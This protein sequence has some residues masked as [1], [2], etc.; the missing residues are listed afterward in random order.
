MSLAAGWTCPQCDRR[1]P[2][3][4]QTCRCGFEYVP[5]SDDEIPAAAVKSEAGGRLASLLLL[6]VVLIGGGMAAGVYLTRADRLGS[7]SDRP[8][9]LDPIAG[10]PPAPAA[11]SP[12]RP[13]ESEPAE[14]RL[15]LPSSELPVIPPAATPDRTTRSIEDIVS[16]SESAVALIESGSGRGAGFF[17]SDDRVLTNA[18]VVSGQAFVTVRLSDGKTLPARIEAQL[19]DVDIALLRTSSPHPFRAALEMGSAAGVRAGQEVIAIG[20]PLGLQNTVTRGI[21]SAVRNTGGVVLIQIDASLNPGNSGGPLLDRAGRVIGINTLR[22]GGAQALGFAVAINH[23]QALLSGRGDTAVT[24]PSGG[25]GGPTLAGPA[26]S[27]SQRRQGQA[28]FERALQ[29]LSQRADQIDANWR[30]FQ[31]N[32]LVNPQSHDGQRE[33]FL[34]RDQ[35]PTFKTVDVWCANYL[36]NLKQQ[37]A[38]FSEVMARS[39][40]EA[41][42]AG[43]YPGVLREA[44]RRHR[45]DWAGWDR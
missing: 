34:V 13:N 14:P 19:P 5:T 30:R 31:S 24:P 22:V 8:P 38:E 26:E 20:S 15:A 44:R 4:V 32:C 35:S 36:A 18:H 42:R 37:V 12:P 3:R 21:V 43:V 27:D 10:V 6:A 9:S 2:S 25:V 39:A 45:L 23:A 40:D 41:R 11:P 28:G 33:W 29:V 16:A 17:I 7:S 1:V